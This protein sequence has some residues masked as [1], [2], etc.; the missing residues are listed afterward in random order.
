MS[1]HR[2]ASSAVVHPVNTCMET[3]LK[4]FY[5]DISAIETL[6]IA[7]TLVRRGSNFT[8]IFLLMLVHLNVSS[9]TLIS[10]TKVSTEL[11]TI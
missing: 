9:S 1:I 2:K 8:T 4:C 10:L 6:T 11:P 5:K 3:R 7:R